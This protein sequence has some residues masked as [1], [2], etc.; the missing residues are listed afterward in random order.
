[1]IEAYVGVPGSGKSYML[2]KKGLDSLAKGRRVFANFGFLRNNVYLYL[3]KRHR[4]PHVRAVQLADSIGE[5]RSYSEM[6]DVTQGVLLFDEAHGWLPST[7]GARLVPFEVISFWSQHRKVG[8]DVFLATQRFGSIDVAVRELIANTFL[9]RPAPW[10][11]K[12]AMRWRYGKL[13]MMRYTA[14]MDDTVG[15]LGSKAKGLIEGSARTSMVVLDPVAARC[16]DT[17][18]I[19]EP[20]I[21]ALERELDTKGRAAADRLGMRWDSTRY[22]G[23]GEA[24]ARDWLPELSIADVARGIRSGGDLAAELRRRL[25][26]AYREPQ[27]AGA[28]RGAS[29][30]GG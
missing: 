6:L 11:A 18:A 23:Y 10:T 24:R 14:I 27:A 5:I 2:V 28:A 22:Q 25:D 19:F 15:D 16:Y 29:A 4:L 9:V 20:P 17:L 21:V 8:I 26:A 3:R 12:L 13:P 1:M 30:A 7:K